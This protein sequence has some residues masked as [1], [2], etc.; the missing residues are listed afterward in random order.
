[1][2]QDLDLHW[3]RIFRVPSPEQNL[4]FDPDQ[5][6]LFYF[7]HKKTQFFGKNQAL[8]SGPDPYLQILQTLDPDPQIFH[9]LDSDPDL[10]ELDADLNPAS[11]W[12]WFHNPI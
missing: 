9:T 1:L 2:N 5:K 6:F 8:N 12:A 3:I 10:H 7:F 11:A 4:H